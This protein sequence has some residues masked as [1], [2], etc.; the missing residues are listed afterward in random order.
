MKRIPTRLILLEQQTCIGQGI[1]WGSQSQAHWNEEDRVLSSRISKAMGQNLSLWKTH[2]KLFLGRLNT[3]HPSLYCWAPRIPPPTPWSKDSAAYHSMQHGKGIGCQRSKKG[4]LPRWR[5][6]WGY[7]WIGRIPKEDDA[8]A[9]LGRMGTMYETT[10]SWKLWDSD[11][12][13]QHD[14]RTC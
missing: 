14:L 11:Q 13:P 4:T 3:Y 10:S 8:S 7:D 12:Q 9:A 6:W 1:R 5:G 2:L